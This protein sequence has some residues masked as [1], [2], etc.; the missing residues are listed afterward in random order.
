MAETWGSQRSSEQEGREDRDLEVYLQKLEQAVNFQV[1][2]V[3][4]KDK[5]FQMNRLHLTVRKSR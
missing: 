2:R 5:N 3:I 4:V 1:H